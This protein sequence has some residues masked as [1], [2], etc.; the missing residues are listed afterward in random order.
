MDCSRKSMVAV[1]EEVKKDILDNFK[2]KLNKEIEE[3]AWIEELKNQYHIIEGHTL[4][5]VKRTLHYY[6]IKNLEY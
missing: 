6:L 3:S 2:K 5:D 4:E 1:I